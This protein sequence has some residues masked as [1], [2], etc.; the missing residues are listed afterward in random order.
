MRR[1]PGFAAITVITLALGIGANTAVFT[2]VNGVLLRPLPYA[3]PE[4]LVIL[5]YGRT[6]RMGPYYSPP[7]YRD[8]TA[9]SGVFESW[10]ALNTTTAN[11]TGRGDPERVD[12]AEVTA[13]FFKVLGVAPRFGRALQGSDEASGGRVVVLSDAFWRRRFGAQPDIVGSIVQM[14]G[15]AYTI[16]GVAGPELAF[17]RRADFWRPLIFKPRDIAP[18]ARG[19]QWITPIAR[20]KPGVTLAQA[21]SAMD[22]VASRL[23]EQFSRSNRDRRMGARLLHDQMVQGVRPALVV[24]LGA[25]T[26]VLVIACAN[27]ANLLLA[28]ASGRTREI[29]V[30]AAL[31]AGRWR[32]VRQFLAESLVVGVAGGAAGLLVAFW[33]TRALAA[34]GPASIPRLSDVAID[35]RV[36]TFTVATAVATSVLFGL[37]PAIATTSGAVARFLGSAGRGSIG[38][39]GTGT[40]KM[41][42]VCEMALAVILLVGAGLLLRSY[43]R[44]I[45]VDPGFNPDRVLTFHVALPDAKYHGPDT[46]TRFANDIVDRLAHEPG[47][48]HASAVYGL[49]LDFDYSIQTSFTRPGDTDSANGPVAG[50]RIITPGYFA[51]MQIPLR[52]GR[53][54]DAHDDATGPEVAMI[55]EQAARRFWPGQN[56]IGQQIHLG[57]RMTEARSGQKTIVGVVGDVKFGGLDEAVP[58]EIYIPHPQ[59]PVGDLTIAVRTAADPLAFVPVARADVAALDRELPLADIHPMNDLVGRSVAERRFTMLLLTAFASLAVALAL[60]GVYGLL[61]YVVTQRTP[62]MGVRLAM[63]A[64]PA[65]VVRLFLREGAALTAAGVVAGLAGAFAGARL[66]TSLLFGVSATDPVTFAGVSAFLVA[67]ALGASYLPA[68]RAARVDPMLALRAE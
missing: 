43:E 27:V 54:F 1:Q 3:D 66:L 42:V 51:T 45:G 33:C 63:G 19:A 53:L 13:D 61:A 15:A 48:E 5:L 41:L 35:S 25:V 18:Q 65:D 62:E 34:L 6:A 56:P 26:L 29:A 38:S 52:A 44:L 60:V 2:V 17:P 37:A 11:V 20:L 28:R 40:R 68:R 16:V 50:M 32:L 58:P 23:A 31:G 9:Q 4:R 64:S 57:V 49:P 55:N 24:L 59:H 30:R 14:D 46:A 39:G 12:G 47:V 67:V 36:L 10:A 21:N 22:A 7:N 8:V